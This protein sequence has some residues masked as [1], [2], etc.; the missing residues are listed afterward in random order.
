MQ[1]GRLNNIIE[2][3]IPNNNNN[4][5]DRYGNTKFKTDINY[6]VRCN[7]FPYYS[8]NDDGYK[9]IFP[10]MYRLQIR[11]LYNDDN[12]KYTFTGYERFIDKKTNKIFSIVSWDDYTDDTTK[13]YIELVVQE[14][15]EQ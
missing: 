6:T 12:T 2:I 1:A 3:Q 8:R 7:K 10:G 4:V 5:P 9:I 11:P 14:N 13:N 15:N